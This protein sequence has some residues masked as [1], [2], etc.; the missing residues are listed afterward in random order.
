MNTASTLTGA[1]L[2]AV[3]CSNAQDTG[4]QP[5]AAPDVLICKDGEKFVGHL[6][7][8]SDSSLVFKSDAAGRPRFFIWA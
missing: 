8:S 2:L 6:V 1:V 3:L 5:S 4:P 7:S